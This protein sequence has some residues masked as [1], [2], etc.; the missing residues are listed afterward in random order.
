MLLQVQL[1]ELYGAPAPALSG[2]LTAYGAHLIA[3]PSQNTLL[4]IKAKGA[5]T[6]RRSAGLPSLITGILG[7]DPGGPLFH[8]AIRDLQGEVDAVP[9]VVAKYGDPLPQVHALNCLKAIFISTV[10]GPSSEQYIVSALD[11]AGS[12]LRSKSW[13]IR[14]CGLMLF[15]ALIDRLIGS[16]D[17]QNL[18]EVGETKTARISYNDYPNLFE[19][20]TGLLTPDL[21]SSDSTEA[22][23]E[24]VFPA[25][26]II[27]RMPPPADQQKAIRS[28]V[29]KLCESPH[30]HVR[31]MAARTFARLVH[32]RELRPILNDILP[33]SLLHQNHVHG[34]LLCISYL[35]QPRLRQLEPDSSSMYWRTIVSSLLM[36]ANRCFGLQSSAR[37]PRIATQY[38]L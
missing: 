34:K 38:A 10:L 24:S 13:A 2:M 17:T 11:I 18:A 16:T 22:A 30:W 27:Q 7:A 31:D 6:T 36:K 25:L 37:T 8:L 14:N 5:A 32:D 12:C 9:N 26:K 33:Q 21:I 23:L 20:V 3:N 28:L 35:V 1:I 15:R 29:F 19:I 4:C